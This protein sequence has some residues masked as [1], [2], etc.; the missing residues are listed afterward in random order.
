MSAARGTIEDL[1]AYLAHK[2][3]YAA[4]A[5]FAATHK[6]IKVEGKRVLASRSCSSVSEITLPIEIARVSSQLVKDGTCVVGTELR[7]VG[8]AE[9][10]ECIT[11]VWLMQCSVSPVKSSFA[12]ERIQRQFPKSAKVLQ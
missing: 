7:F 1:T 9:I 12:R 10:A 2:T 11:D 5:D 4:N 6:W 3:D 8:K